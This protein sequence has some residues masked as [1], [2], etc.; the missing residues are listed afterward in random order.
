MF[1]F[2]YTD[3]DFIKLKR[4]GKLKRRLIFIL[5]VILLAALV[6]SMTSCAKAVS[7]MAEK[8]IEKTIESSMGI[9]NADIDLNEEGG[10]ISSDTGEIAF[11][12]DAEVPEGWPSSVPVY[13]D[14]KV[15]YSA[16][17]K[18]SNNKDTFAILAEATKGTVKEIY[19]WH[20]SKMSGW[21]TESDYFGTSDGNDS[22]NLSWKND[23][24]QIL[25]MCGSDGN[26]INYTFTVTQ[27]SE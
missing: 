5:S 8:A 2:L 14:I 3:K 27:Q 21:E 24:Y 17:S 25:L 11:G 7:K 6:F 13:P 19:E 9:E 23:Q 12:D 15:T 18:D 22:F 1:G 16:K 4:G 26:I 10:K 20:K